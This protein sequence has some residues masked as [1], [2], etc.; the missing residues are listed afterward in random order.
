MI[1][2]SK[3]INRIILIKKQK[4]F[5][6][7]Q[8]IFFTILSLLDHTDFIDTQ[9]QNSNILDSIYFISNL[10][11]TTLKLLDNLQIPKSIPRTKKEITKKQFEQKLLHWKKLLLFL[12]QNVTLV[13]IWS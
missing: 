4:H 12:S 5:G 7:A 6:Q 13:I 2:N 10:N 8:N 1:N 11:N 9:N 3:L